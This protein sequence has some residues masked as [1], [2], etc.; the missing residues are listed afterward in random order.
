MGRALEHDK[1]IDVLTWQVEKLEER[2]KIL[3]IA[4]ITS[5][6][7][8]SKLE[9]EEEV[10][11]EDEDWE[12]EEVE[13]EE[14]EEEP[15][16]EEKADEDEDETVAEKAAN[17]HKSISTLKKYGINVYT[18]RKATPAPRINTPKAETF[19]WNSVDKSWDELDEI[20][21]EN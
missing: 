10:E 3:A 18:G 20:V 7:Y 9:P 1:K 14:E 13:E 5:D 2:V 8:V 17:L 12:E 11:Y 6:T 19:D 21:G 16:E 4:L 15:E